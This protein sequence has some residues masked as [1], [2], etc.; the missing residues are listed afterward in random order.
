M[1]QPSDEEIAELKAYAKV[2]HIMIIQEQMG[3]CR[4]CGKHDDLRCGLCFDCVFPLC[5]KE[6][7]EKKRIVKEVNGNFA[8]YNFQYKDLK[9]KIH[10]TRVEGLC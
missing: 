8:I 2:K 6:K 3:Y 1:N 9:G 10:C 5:P 4:K 7:C